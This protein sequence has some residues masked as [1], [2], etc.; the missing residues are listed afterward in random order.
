MYEQE[1]GKCHNIFTV[2]FRLSKKPFKI[3]R[4]MPEVCTEQV[5]GKFLVRVSTETLAILI[6]KISAF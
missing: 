6:K 3:C 5:F 4:L 2:I 1:R